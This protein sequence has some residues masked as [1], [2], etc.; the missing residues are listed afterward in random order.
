MFIFERVD[1]LFHHCDVITQFRQS[2]VGRLDFTLYVDLASEKIAADQL[3]EFHIYQVKLHSDVTKESCFI[4]KA[5][6]T[7]YMK[8]LSEC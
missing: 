7:K 3:G 2:Q 1:H 5:N 6:V 4:L 8:H